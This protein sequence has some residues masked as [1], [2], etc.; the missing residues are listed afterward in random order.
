MARHGA[1]PHTLGFC[2]VG[3]RP[4]WDRLRRGRC[5]Q[6]VLLPGRGI[7][8]LGHIVRRDRSL[9]ANTDDW[10]GLMVGWRDVPTRAPGDSRGHEAGG[11]PFWEVVLLTLSPV[12]PTTLD[13]SALRLELADGLLA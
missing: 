10:R 7:H 3:L 2:R 4:G 11:C 1:A 6:G 5:A 9:R 13:T 12:Y 8:G